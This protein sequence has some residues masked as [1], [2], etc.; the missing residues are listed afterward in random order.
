MIIIGITYPNAPGARFDW[1]YYQARHLPMIGR[2]LGSLGLK[3]AS[4][5]KGVEGAD[6]GDPPFI[7]VAFLTFASIEIARSVLASAEARELIADIA[8]FT[9]IVPAIQLS[10]AV[11]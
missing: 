8:N 1:T 11:P 5:I 4:V 7:A 6:G 3:S 2:K 9:D 10:S